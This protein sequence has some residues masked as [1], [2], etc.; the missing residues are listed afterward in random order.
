MTQQ[1]YWYESRT[2]AQASDRG[3]AV[4]SSSRALTAPLTFG[5]LWI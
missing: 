3:G 1:P 5:S 2:A 4:V